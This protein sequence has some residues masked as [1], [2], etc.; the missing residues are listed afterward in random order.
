MI[1]LIITFEFW[2]ILQNIWRRVVS[3]ILNNI[4]P[5]NIFLAWLLPARFYQ[6]RKAIF[7]LTSSWLSSISQVVTLPGSV[8]PLKIT[9]EL[10]LPMLRLLSSQE[11]G[12]K[13]YWKWSKPCH[14]GIHWNALSEY[15]QMSTNEPRFQSFFM[16]FLYHFVVAKLATSNIRILQHIVLARLATTSMKVSIQ[17]TKHFEEICWLGTHQ[18]LTFQLFF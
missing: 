12:C 1:L 10:T 4:P 14:V 5:S 16:F 11:Q 13:D 15:S 8:I 3:N 18:H 2:K 7:G 17:S 9:Q 6:N